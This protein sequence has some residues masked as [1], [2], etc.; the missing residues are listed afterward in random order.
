MVN[1]PP[2]LG[3]ANPLS[4]NRSPRMRPIPS[5]LA[6]RAFSPPPFYCHPK[7]FGAIWS[8][9]SACSAVAL[10]FFGHCGW[11]EEAVALHWFPHV[12]RT[13]VMNK[14][15]VYRGW[16]RACLVDET[17]FVRVVRDPCKRAVSSFHSAI[18]NPRVCRAD[19]SQFLGRE[20]TDA[21]GFSFE[22]FLD[23]LESIDI[24]SC[25]IHIRQQFN[26]LERRVRPTLVVNAD[27]GGLQEGLNAFED[28]I[29]LP[30]SDFRSPPL[31]DA[32][33]EARR[34]HMTPRFDP[35]RDYGGE[36]LGKGGVN[37]LWPSDQSL[38]TAA[39]RRRVEN[40]YVRD[41]DAYQPR[42]GA[43]TDASAL[44][45]RDRIGPS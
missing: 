23:F 4:T 17:P 43:K 11:L 13:G 5:S 41:F 30:P 24:S 32:M 28:M 6:S 31:A 8:A 16:R 29:G 36:Q 37:G 35:G 33:R 19:I 25:E 45:Q 1:L 44:D 20:V 2:S 18:W 7:R 12:Y 34:K 26:E 10:W 42:Q 15:A 38:L 27:D 14:D 9:R 3:P 40:I 21:D 22:E 39:T